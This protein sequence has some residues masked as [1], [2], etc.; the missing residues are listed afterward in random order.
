LSDAPDSQITMPFDP[1]IVRHY[2]DAAHIIVALPE[3]LQE[4]TAEGED[5]VVQS[6][7]QPTTLL[8]YL[9]QN[10]LIR[11]KGNV[12]GKLPTMSQHQ[13]LNPKQLT[14]QEKFELLRQC[15]AMRVVLQHHLEEDHHHDGTSVDDDAAIIVQWLRKHGL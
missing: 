11:K 13:S 9:K 3:L 2:G 7:Q 4:A 12:N 6:I 14:T 5:N 10:K 15:A 1:R 8:R